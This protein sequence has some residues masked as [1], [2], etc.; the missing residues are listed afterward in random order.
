MEKQ[1]MT[2]QE[3]SWI[4]YD[5]AN[6]VFATIMMTAIMPIYFNSVAKAAGQ[7]GDYWWGIGSSVAMF[8]VA[9]LA[10]FIGALADYKGYKK[11]IFLFF[12][13]I[14]LAFTLFSAITNNWVLLLISYIVSS[15][16]FSGGN[17]VYDSFLTD[18]TTPDRM[19]KISSY[20]FAF[21]YIGGSTIP[22]IFAIALMAL[23][24]AIGISSAMAV[25]ISIV[26]TVLWWGIFSIPFIKN[27][28][29]KHSL[30]KP[31]QK[32]LSETL[33]SIVRTAKSIFKDKKVFYFILAYFFYIDGV[34]TIIKMSTSYGTT[35]GLDSTGMVLALLVTQI[36][37]FPCSII[38][39]KLAKKFG[40]RKMIFAAV[41][42]YFLI[43]IV[44]FVMG[45]G[46]EANFLTN[47]QALALFW[48]LAVLVGT[49][50]G[51][52]QAISR[53]YFGKL[54]PPERSGEY[55]GFFD[56][57]GKF[58]SVMGPALYA[59]TARVTGSSALAILSIILL[60]LIAL[61]ILIAGRKYM[62]D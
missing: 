28:N 50:Q 60:F 41:G 59:L 22:F 47:T 37:A 11:K 35:L 56:I 43:C 23:A 3:K 38:F 49:V 5:W 45:Y 30:D 34:G 32:L 27:V 36:V 18:V 14:G 29:H 12:L 8:V 10:P 16:G 52:I 20:G 61:I 51:G 7:Q 31:Q 44:G 40:A 54:I 58:A 1:K 39:S 2:K 57:F 46:I 17:V 6:S 42:M 13:F 26:I 9:I 55:F 53:S 25:K 48:I 4:M 24:P 21:G 19:D 15:I 33:R 62:V